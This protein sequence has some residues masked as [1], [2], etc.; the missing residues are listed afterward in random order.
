MLAAEN[1]NQGVVRAVG[2]STTDRVGRFECAER[3]RLRGT[4]ARLPCPFFTFTISRHV[5]GMLRSIRSGG[6]ACG[7][8]RRVAASRDGAPKRVGRSYADEGKENSGKTFSNINRPLR[9]LRLVA[10]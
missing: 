6:V 1:P 5:R 9:G 4:R 8:V 3:K 10:V 2:L 7:A